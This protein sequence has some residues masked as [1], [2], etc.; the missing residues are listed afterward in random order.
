MSSFD[1]GRKKVTSIRKAVGEPRKIPSWSLKKMAFA[2]GLSLA[3]WGTAQAAPTYTI[4]DLG[5]LGGTISSGD[6]INTSGEVTG[7]SATSGNAAIH[8]FLY[9]GSTMNDL[10]TL[11]G[12]SAAGYATNTSGEVTGYSGTSNNSSFHAFLYDGSTMQDLGTL[13]GTGDSYGEGINYKGQVTGYSD[14][15]A[16]YHAFLYDGSTMQDL[17]T[18]GGADSYGYG[19]NGN[20]QVT[21]SAD[22]SVS[23]ARHAFLYD[24]ANGMTDLGTLGGAISRGQ[25]INATG[26]V[27]GFSYTSGNAATHAFL[28]DG[29]TMIDLGTLGGSSSYGYGINASGEVVGQSSTSGNAA[30][31]AFLYDGLSMLDLNSLLTNGTGWNLTYAAAINDAGQI[32]GYGMENINGTNYKHAFLLNPVVTT[33]SV[34]EP[35][36]LSLLGLGLLGIALSRRRKAAV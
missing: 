34:P 27:T 26:E 22:T 15:S 17:G 19:I 16:G 36:S 1:F 25:G 13:G 11:G 8:A 2:L 18:L 14:I 12:N 4:T 31:H 30:Q 6:G 5:T 29:S 24:S 7:Y 20:G 32:T 33:S 21:G 9:D 10:G 3:A 28:Y 23:G 35:T